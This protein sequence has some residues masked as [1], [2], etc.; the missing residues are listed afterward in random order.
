MGIKL[1]SV[2]VAAGL[3][4]PTMRM[5]AVIAGGSECDDHIHFE[6][7]PVRSIMPHIERL[8]LAR[9]DDLDVDALA[10]RVRKELITSGGV[11]VGR[12]E[13]AAWSRTRLQAS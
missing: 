4:S 1:H 13:V 2:F 9:A 12:A 10:E 6:V 5:E 11:I 3:P 8:G 7:D